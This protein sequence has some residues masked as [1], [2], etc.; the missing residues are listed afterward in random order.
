MRLFDRDCK[1]HVL[2]DRYLLRIAWASS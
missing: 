1:P 2:T